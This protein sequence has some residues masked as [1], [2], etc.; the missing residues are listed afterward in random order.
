[1]LA[2]AQLSRRRRQPLRAPPRESHLAA[3]RTKVA[4]GR[5]SDRARSQRPTKRR[6]ILLVIL[7]VDLGPHKYT[8][9]HGDPIM[10]ID[11]S[12]LL[13]AALS[14]TSISIGI[15]I[16]ISVLTTALV[17]NTASNL[18]GNIV[19]DSV[20]QAKAAELGVEYVTDVGTARKRRDRS[21]RHFVHGTTTNVWQ[22]LASNI[23]IFTDGRPLDFGYGFYTRLF[24][25]QG[26]SETSAFAIRR[27][28]A[29]IV[30]TNVPSNRTGG[31]PFVLVFSMTWSAWN[32]LTKKYYGQPDAPTPDFSP[33]VNLFRSISGPIFAFKDVVYGPTAVRSGGTWVADP[34]FSNQYKFEAGGIPHL[35]PVFLLPAVDLR[36]PTL[37]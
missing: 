20:L 23:Q 25:I 14:T 35:R 37:A 7:E 2:G 1:M 5:L 6:V 12:G 34:A 4:E 15:S 27:S 28:N 19:Q 22:G 8:Y 3:P 21:K 10:M 36:G 11:P 30:D 31:I 29:R 16:G 32:S 17:L 9:V 26:Y 13:G 18:I 24:T 33:D